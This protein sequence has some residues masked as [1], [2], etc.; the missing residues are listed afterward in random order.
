MTPTT[1][2]ASLLLLSA[3]PVR[4][5]DPD[6]RADL[7]ATQMA[8]DRA[9]AEVSRPSVHFVLG[10]RE[11]TRAYRIRGVGAFFVLPPRALPTPD[12]GRV[13]VFDRRQPRP[14][15][16]K[17]SKEEELAL[18]AMQAQLEAMQRD[19]DAMQLEAERAL[20]SVE[21]NV[22]IRLVA[23][24]APEPP[25]PPLPPALAMSADAPEPPPPPPW[26]FWFG[27]SETSDDRSPE[28]VVAD[29]QSAVTAALEA[30][31]PTLR[32][33]GAD[34]S[35]LVAV[36]FLPNHGFDLEEPSRPLRSLVVKV[37]KRDLS[38]RA[39]GKITPEELRRRIEYTQY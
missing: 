32:A 19:A 35:V 4:A 6:P 10:G 23:P 12:R 9:V 18:R 39:A 31:G 16:Q 30:T 5:D 8:L 38:E 11:A 27:S 26:H 29:V 36:D 33:L 22:R 17:P 1:L 21:R 24:S 37:K 25:E 20:E 7:Q 15:A 14:L 3:L 13:F 2:V 28:R 34:E